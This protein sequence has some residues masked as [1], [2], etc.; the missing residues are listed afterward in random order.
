M[1]ILL[2]VTGGIAAYKA[3]PVISMLRRRGHDV[4]VTMTPAACRLVDPATFRTIS[5]N[6]VAVDLFQEDDPGEVRH[7]SWA[8]WAERALVAPATANTVGKLALGI[9]DNMLTT[10][11][12]ACEAPLYIAPAMNPH[13]LGKEAVRENLRLLKQRG[14]CILEPASGHLACGET[15]R[16]RLP[17]PEEIVR[18]LLADEGVLTGKRVLVTA[19]PTSE[20]IDPVRSITN[21]SSGR[22][23]YALAEAALRAGADVSLISGPVEISP[24]AGADVTYVRTAQQ[25]RDAVMERAARQDIVIACAA[26]SD[27]R[28]VETALAKIHKT[29]ERL[30]LIL[31]RTPDILAELGRNKQFYLIGFAAETQDMLASARRKLQ[32]KNLDMIVANDVSKA[33]IGFESSENA[34]TVLQA[35]GTQTELERA[36]KREIA[37]QLIRLIAAALDKGN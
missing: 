18:F 32:A 9:A 4:R 19:G 2:G 12:L 28:P 20:P 16:G 31:E 3:L 6:H 35:D 14:A 26:V 15:G 11:F 7:I 21:R 36:P 25:M 24:P 30:T 27:Y 37:S 34:V 10:M 5:G 29:D 13:M 17:E 33:G 8:E 23:G 1:N 22:M